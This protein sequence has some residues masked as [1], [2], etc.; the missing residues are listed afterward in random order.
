MN[1]SRRPP[2]PRLMHKRAM[3]RIH[4][5]NNPVVHIARQL[6][7]KMRRPKPPRKLRH[8]RHRRQ[9][10]PHPPSPRLGQIGPRLPTP[11]LARISPRINLPRL[12][13]LMARQRRNLQTLSRTRLKPPSVVLTSHRLPIKPPG[14]KWNPPVRT[15]IPHRKQPPILLPSHK[16]RHTQQQS[17]SR[18]PRAQL[19]R[20]QSRIPIP[21]DQLRR[22]PTHLN[23]ITHI[24]QPT[25]NHRKVDHGSQGCP[26]IKTKPTCVSPSLPV[27]S[28]LVLSVSSLKSAVSLP[29]KSAGVSYTDP[30]TPASDETRRNRLILFAL[31]LALYASFT[32]LAPPLLDDADSVHA[33][34]SREMLL[35]H[36]WVTL[37]AN[38]IR[39][40]EK[41][42]LLYWSMAAS[43]RIFGIHTAAARLPLALPLP[44][45]LPPDAS[46]RRAF[47]SPEQPSSGP[48]AGLYAGLLLLSSFGIFIFT[49]IIIP[50]AIVCLWLTVALFAYWLTEQSTHAETGVPH[51]AT[52]E[53]LSSTGP[54]SPGAPSF[55]ALSR[56]MGET[57]FRPVNPF[58]CYTFAAACALN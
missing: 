3:R 11:L 45:P 7:L 27:L 4:Q 41:A 30:V 15:K 10:P 46:P 42:P 23:K 51:R 29:S 9:P 1:T 47:N 12:Q 25:T 21:K 18:L 16:Q 28:I 5:P 54:N 13:R 20:P 44:P 43:F 26:R 35:R 38:G 24:H 53:P 48:R 49:R 57:N 22:R 14:R 55:A 31:W 39:Y 33:E 50:D 32:L 34:V 56:R 40:L 6:R 19:I 2:P 37:Y 52:H 58:L 8:L 36:D 17:R